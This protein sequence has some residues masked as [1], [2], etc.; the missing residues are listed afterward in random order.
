M[1]R[2]NLHYILDILTLLMIMT[3]RADYII[4]KIKALIQ[5]DDDNGNK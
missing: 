5:G 3:D 4:R 2:N 1:N